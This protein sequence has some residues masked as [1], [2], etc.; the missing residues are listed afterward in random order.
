[1]DSIPYTVF[2]YSGTAINSWIRI[3]IPIEGFPWYA[4]NV[5]RHMSEEGMAIGPRQCLYKAHPRLW[6]TW[7]FRLH[8]VTWCFSSKR[9]DHKRP[10][11]GLES[12]F[13]QSCTFVFG[14]WTCIC[15]DVYL[16]TWNANSP[17]QTSGIVLTHSPRAEAERLRLKVTETYHWETY[18][19]P[20]LSGPVLFPTLKK[21]GSDLSSSVLDGIGMGWVETTK[22]TCGG[23]D[24]PRHLQGSQACGVKEAGPQ[25][26]N[27]GWWRS[28]PFLK[29][30]SEIGCGEIFYAFPWMW[31]AM[32]ADQRY[33]TESA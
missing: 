25:W 33:V 8:M 32:V 17:I 4:T 16:G 28:Y 14:E 7:K 20:I 22:I 29:D 31:S 19:P 13:P 1:M 11:T 15:F 30:A 27:F 24:Q 2:V 12:L 21:L 9:K 6:T 23:A 3:D 5:Q 10:F 26:Q 18:H